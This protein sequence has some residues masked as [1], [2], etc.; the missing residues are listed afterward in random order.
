MLEY[1]V[2]VHIV[3]I[4]LI[5]GVIWLL[6]IIFGINSHLSELPS[7]GPQEFLISYFTEG[8]LLFT[9]YPVYV[10]FGAILMGAYDLPNWVAA[11]V[12]RGVSA[13]TGK[14]GSM[15]GLKWVRS[16]RPAYPAEPIWYHALSVE[17]GDTFTKAPTSLAG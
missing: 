3:G 5:F 9:L 16:P 6:T 12:V 13:L 7:K 17:K 4:A 14:I 11:A 1:S 2:Y 8:V 15:P 10:V